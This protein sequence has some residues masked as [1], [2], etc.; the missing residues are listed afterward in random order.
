MILDKA[1]IVNYDHNHRF[2][3]LATINTII[4][5]DR[6]TFIVQATQWL[7]KPNSHEFVTD[8][9]GRLFLKKFKRVAS[10]ETTSLKKLAHMSHRINARVNVRC[11]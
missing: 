2:I 6:K 3:V 11:V 5:Y 7:H 10:I 1:M 9:L 4:N 8:S